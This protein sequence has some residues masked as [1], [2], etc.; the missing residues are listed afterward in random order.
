MTRLHST[1]PLFPTDDGWPYPDPTSGVGP[2]RAEYDEPD[3]AFLDVLADPRV[4]AD[5]T[6]EERTVLRRR[7]GFDGPPAT[8][9]ALAAELG[10]PR[11]DVV[12]LLGRAVDKVRVRLTA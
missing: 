4:F 12:D 8:L 7:F 10:R 9:K 11:R 6:A 1:L 3:P 2:D 5:L